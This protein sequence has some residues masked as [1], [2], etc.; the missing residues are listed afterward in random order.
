MRIHCI[1]SRLL[2]VAFIVWTFAGSACFADESET[3]GK[4]FVFS[5]LGQKS[6]ENQDLSVLFQVY[7]KHPN[8]TILEYSSNAGALKNHCLLSVSPLNVA[9]VSDAVEQAEQI[10]RAAAKDTIA[11]IYHSDTMTTTGLVDLL[12][13]VSATHNGVRIGH[14]GIVAHGGPGEIDIGNTDHLSLATIPSHATSLE[15]LRSVLTSDARLDLYSCSVAA[16]ASGKSFVNE[17]SDITG[18]AVF[19]S[20][21]PVGTVHRADLFLEY[22]TGQALANKELFSIQEMEAIPRLLLATSVVVNMTTDV[23]YP[24]GTGLISLRNALAIANS[25]TSPTTITFDPTVFASAQTIFLT[26]DCFDCYLELSNTSQPTTITGPAAGVTVCGG[27]STVEGGSFFVDSNVTATLANITFSDACL[28]N[29]GE[30]TLT[31]ITISG[32]YGDV[33][34]NTGTATIVNVTVLGGD[35]TQRGINNQG[36]TVT[37]NNVIVSGS[38]DGAIINDGTMTLNNVTISGNDCGFFEGGIYNQGKA[39]LTNVNISNNNGGGI[40][41]YTGGNAM[42]FN[43]IIA[44]NTAGS[45]IENHGIV[46]LN[47]VTISDN[48]NDIEMFHTNQGGGI[49]NNGNATLTNVTISGNTAPGDS[50]SSYIYGGGGIYNDTAGTVT[51]TNVTVSGNTVPGGLGTGSGGGGIINMAPAGHLTIANSI[52]AG[53]TADNLGPDMYGSFNSLGNNLIGKTNNSSGWKGTDLTGSIASPLSAKLGPL[54]DNGGF[55]K[56]LPLLSGSPAID[57]GSNTLAASAGVT[58]DQRGL[59]RPVNGIVDIGAY[60]YP[61]TYT[62]NFDLAEKGTRTGGGALSQIISYGSAATEPT[63]KAYTGWI[64]TGWDK[65][66]NNI[67]EA[68]TVTAQYSPVT[69]TVTF[70]LAGKGARTGGGELS[71]TINYGTAATAPIVTAN[72]GWTFINWDK[73]F[74]SVTSDLTVTAQYNFAFTATP[75]WNTTAPAVALSWWMPSGGATSYEVY[76]NNV[77]IYPASGTYTGTSFDDTKGLISGQNY[78]YYILAKNSVGSTQSITVTVTASNPPPTVTT[79]RFPLDGYTPYTCP[80]SSVFDHSMPGGRYTGNGVVTAFNGESG[81]VKDPNVSTPVNGVLLYSYKKTDGSAF[82]SGVVNYR[83]TSATGSTILNYDGHPGYDYKVASGTPVYAVADGTVIAIAKDSYNAKYVQL[84]HTT[85]GYKSHY[86]HLSDNSVVGLNQTVSRGQLIGYSGNTGLSSG[87]HLHF[88]VKTIADDVSVDPYGWNGSVSDPYTAATN[89][90]L[91]DQNSPDIPVISV[92]PPVISVPAMAEQ[93]TIIISNG[94]GGTLN[95]SASI[96]QGATWLNIASGATGTGSGTILVNIS[97]NS[98]SAGREGKIVISG[99]SGVSSREVTV[100]QSGAVANAGTLGV[101]LYGMYG[102]LADAADTKVSL[103]V[104]PNIPQVNI[105]SNPAT[106]AGIPPNTTNGYL[107]EGWSKSRFPTPKPGNEYEFWDSQHVKVNSNTA[108]KLTRGY[109]PF[110]NRVEVKQQTSDGSWKVITDGEPIFSGTKV[111]FDVKVMEENVNTQNVHVHLTFGINQNTSNDYDF[112]LQSGQLSNPLNGDLA[113]KTFSFTATVDANLCGQ[114]STQFYYAAEVFTDIGG[115]PILTDSLG[116]TATFTAAASNSKISG[117]IPWIG[118]SFPVFLM[119]VDGTPIEPN[120]KT[121]IVTHGI[122]SNTDED[123]NN[124]TIRDLAKAIKKHEG[125]NGVNAQVLLMDWSSLSGY[126]FNILTA[127]TAEL[128]LKPVAEWMHEQLSNYGISGSNVNLA[129]HSLGT[130]ISYYLS[131]QYGNVASIIAFDPAVDIPTNLAIPE[132]D[133]DFSRYSN[134][135]WAFHSST[136][137]GSNYTACTASESFFMKELDE[138]FPDSHGGSYKVFIYML[139]NS[140]GGVSKYFKLSNLTSPLDERKWCFNKYKNVFGDAYEA[141]IKTN[142]AWTE[143]YSIEYRSLA[144][145][146]EIREY[147]SSNSIPVISVFGNNLAISNGDTKTVSS[148]SFLSANNDINFGV[149]AQGSVDTTS[150]IDGTYFGA[151]TQGGEGITHSFT[152]RNPSNA[153]LHLSNFNVPAGF[154]LMSLAASSLAPRA[155]TTLSIRLDTDTLGT[156]SGNVSFTTDDPNALSFIFAISGTVSTTTFIVTPSAGVNGSISP[157]SVQTVNGN[158]KASF[159]ATSEYGYEVNQWLVDGVLAKTGGVAYTLTNVSAN[160]SVQVTFKAVNAS[161]PGI[162]LSGDL[163]FWNTE[164][165]KSVQQTLTISNPGSASLAVNG[166]SLPSGF[167]GNW[168]GTIPVNGS[169]SVTI[170]FSPT[171]STTYSDTLTVN[172]NKNYGTDTATI[173][174]IGIPTSVVTRTLT[175]YGSGASGMTFTVSPSDKNGKSSGKSG[176]SFTFNDNSTVRLTAS[177]VTGK[178]LFGWSGVDSYDSMNKVAMVTMDGGKTAYANYVTKD[179]VGPSLTIN[180]PANG[181]T[182]NTGTIIVQGLA[183][184]A[185][186]GDNGIDSVTVNEANAVGNTADADG[187]ANWSMP[188]SLT[189]GTNVIKVTAKDKCQNAT[190][191]ILSVIYHELPVDTY[192]QLVNATAKTAIGGSKDSVNTYKIYLPAG[193]NLLE[194]KFSGMFGDCDFDVLDPSGTTVRRSTSGTRNELVQIAGSPLAAGYWFIK[195][196]GHTAYSGLSLLAKYSKLTTVPVAPSGVNASKGLFLDKIVVTWSASPGATS[197]V[198]VR[199]TGSTPADTNWTVLGETNDCIFEDNSQSVLGAVPGTLFNYFV[200]GKNPIGIGKFSTGNSGY[201]AKTPAIPG[202]VTASDGTYFDKIRVSWTAVSG[203]TSYLIFRTENTTVP[204]PKEKTYLIGETTAPFLDDFGGNIATAVDGNGVLVVKKY[205]Y[206]IVAKNQNGTT[207]ISKPN[208]GCL[209][210]KGPATVTATSGTYSNRIVVTWAAVPGA[211]AYDVYRS[212]TVS[213]NGTKVASAVNVTECEDSMVTAGKAYYYRV[214]AKYGIHYDSDF[215]LTA[216]VGKAAGLLNLT[217]TSLNGV[218]SG[219][220]V[221]MLKGSALYYSMDVPVGT[222]RLVATLAGTPPPIGTNDCDLF[223]RFANYS[224]VALFNAKGVENKTDEILTVTNPAAGTWYF[225]LYGTTAYSNVMLTVNCYAVADIVLTQIP[226]N[227]LAVPFTALFK[228]KVVDETGAGIPNIIVQVRNPITGL[229]TSLT[230]T[231]ASGLFTYSTL[232]NTEGEHTFDFFFTDMPDTVKGTA[233]HTVATRK[234]CLETNGFFD[235]SAYL[236]ATPV[237]VPL[238]A[239][240]VGLQTFLDIRNGWDYLGTVNPGDKYETMWI[241]NTLVKANDDAQLAAKLDE[242]LYMFFYGVEGAGVGNDTS[243]LSALSA[244]PYVV[245]VN[246]STLST[247]VTNLNTLGIIN[248]TSKAAILA[249]NIGIV[250]VTSLSSPNEAT[251]NNYN[252]S[253]L[254]REQLEILAKLAGNQGTSGITDV[255]YSEVTAKHVTITLANGRKINVVVTGFVK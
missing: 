191:K 42:L 214:K 89:V 57:A 52:V 236:P 168:S 38:G 75:R 18:A 108:C 99:G 186:Y 139:G 166:I 164:V 151:V 43:V 176:T 155:C 98:D 245:H 10:R 106:F 60:E 220:I 109:Y 252:I 126:G 122:W 231:D 73:K 20:D 179:I 129:G 242:G 107:V 194:I 24:Q 247:V 137:C 187:T 49:Y 211:T 217:A 171:S 189:S 40:Y 241:N 212:E 30:M 86:W 81:T 113:N 26:G 229:T 218:Q 203:A 255:K 66:F 200:L 116:A 21:N 188:I 162:L 201:V 69:Y 4:S 165:G 138:Y 14:L 47:N 33:I 62:V 12:A 3:V 1:W 115:T 161:V 112:P 50:G 172:S 51:L 16:G 196:Y 72:T 39:T 136:I 78:S 174:G 197:Y 195:L 97:D 29:D 102:T 182:V 238:Q 230:K 147:E 173:S 59:Q 251:D 204:N 95:Y 239:D 71:Q 5:E 128:W 121:W 167:T 130:Y 249:G 58:Q 85:L 253:L 79:F 225:L 152:I 124:I 83:G 224:T 183:S 74:D 219:N 84:K 237:A 88:E 22:H 37:L 248:D 209:S 216:A 235:F 193:Q 228:G 160:K 221:N 70:Y 119:S 205:Y 77:K 163:N 96:T 64:F 185:G 82:L 192:T 118:M 110:L 105:G 234:G 177:T 207:A 61:P 150:A 34:Y 202:A 169:H 184:D 92:T 68:T 90:C 146:K 28:D 36:G 175:V 104:N 210:K 223:A 63:V 180:S 65:K 190:T 100:N 94:G 141:I 25:S 170:S 215:N 80:I 133:A 145:M 246:S 127:I 158:G 114:T 154:T 125:D 159:A 44:N 131:E 143:P 93:Q 250:A 35:G 117:K 206:W 227:D 181:V 32:G 48:T 76:R 232:I 178:T 148:P 244:V 101:T 243:T 6:F 54:S 213:Q 27:V 46:T 140:N 91:W 31:N 132:T 13:S 120:K 123:K 23:L 17:L 240:I 156:K 15:R 19:A 7:N 45:G 233:S 254:A 103:Y 67:T 53:N 135:S 208:D 41:N 9:L 8:A 87:A 144:D 11:I 55:T 199:N 149:V 198:V 153:T 2:L 222:T 111:K 56:T 134:R 226:V 142:S 157:S